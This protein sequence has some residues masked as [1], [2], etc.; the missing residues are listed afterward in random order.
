MH[1][2]GLANGKLLRR[3]GAT[4][5]RV[6]FYHYIHA[7]YEAM[8]NPEDLQACREA[9]NEL[10]VSFA[11]GKT[12]TTDAFFRETRAK[13]ARRREQ[14]CISVEMECAS[15][16]AVARF[17]DAHFAE[18]FYATDT[19]DDAGWDGGIL[20][21]KGAGLEEVCFRVAVETGKRMR[22]HGGE[23]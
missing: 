19:V 1:H 11:E 5:Y 15:L 16:A 3:T 4:S 20:H 21:E 13:A 22:G 8:V 23:K 10:G 7:D 17:R 2:R 14:G 9:M 12:W 6:I 18:F